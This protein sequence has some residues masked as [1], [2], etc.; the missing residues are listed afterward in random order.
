MTPAMAAFGDT[1]L[2]GD[3][4]SFRLMMFGDLGSTLSVN[5]GGNVNVLR[6]ATPV[7]LGMNVNGSSNIMAKWDEITN[8]NNPA[9]RL[10]VAELWTVSK[11]DMMP[12]GVTKNGEN[13]S[14][15]SW[16]VGATN[17]ISFFNTSTVQLFS[18][19]V[20]MIRVENNNAQ[21]TL[22]NASITDLPS[23]WNGVDV[24]GQTKTLTGQGMNMLRLTY[25]I[26]SVPGPA[27][28]A[29]AGIAGLAASR[30]RRR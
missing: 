4:A 2:A 5:T 19:K 9:T 12:F 25:E 6:G 29:L 11:D 3:T 15:W 26:E 13:F 22:G 17:A 27:P 24:D 14:L 1:V 18:A 10:V 23:K 7:S 16:S 30:R 21:T 20:Q 28:A 8:P